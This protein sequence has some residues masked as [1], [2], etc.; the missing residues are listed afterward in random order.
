M[1]KARTWAN[2]IAVNKRGKVELPESVRDFLSSIAPLDKDSLVGGQQGISV[3]EISVIYKTFE[4]ATPY[5]IIYETA[6][7]VLVAYNGKGKREYDYS[8]SK[9]GWLNDGTDSEGVLWHW[10]DN[11]HMVLMDASRAL[12]YFKTLAATYEKQFNVTP[13]SGVGKITVPTGQG[14]DM[15]NQLRTKEVVPIR[16]A[17]EYIEIPLS[18]LRDEGC[19]IAEKWGA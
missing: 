19:V 14:T 3:P 1:G 18:D 7:N 13:L 8:Q 10:L 5:F 6:D 2:A 11:D 15:F 4:T 17:T 9:P 16:H 12:A